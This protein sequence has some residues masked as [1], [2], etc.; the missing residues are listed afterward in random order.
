MASSFFI[1]KIFWSQELRYTQPTP[2]PA[3]YTPVPVASDVQL[4]LPF[5]NDTGKPKHLHFYNPDCPCSRFNFDHFLSLTKKYDGQID[6]YIV[7]PFAESFERVNRLYGDKLP[8]LVDSNERLSKALGVYSTPQA[9]I[10]DDAGKLYYRGNYNKSRYC[11]DA[12]TN[13]AQIALESVLSGKP[14]PQLGQLSSM[15]YGCQLKEN[16]FNFFI[17]F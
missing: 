6:F 2:I 11:T 9:V 3:D 17:E 13:F 1:G 15:S 14:A 4:K 8:V 10:I 12:K 7:I 16:T 5:I